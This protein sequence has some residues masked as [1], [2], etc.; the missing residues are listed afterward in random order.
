MASG[1]KIMIAVD[2]T[3]V[4][5]YAFTWA[6]HNLL[7]KSDQVIALTAAPFVDITYPSADLASEYGPTVIPSAADAEGN[8]KHVNTDAKKLIAR[9]IAQCAQADISCTG[10]VVK[11][12][13][14][15]WI[16]D[17]ANR[18]GADVIVVGSKGSGALKRMVMGSNSDYV[19]HNATCPVAVVRHVEEELKDHDAL[20]STGGSR[21]VVIAVDESR[22]SVFAF[23]WALENF[24]TE[25]DSVVI[26]HVNQSIPPVTTAGTGEFGIEEV[27]VPSE[28]QGKTEVQALDES[29]KLV[30]KYM[31][32]A[33][34]ETKI[35]CEGI[36]VTGQPELKVIEGLTKLGAD[37]VIIGTHDRSAVSRTLLSSITDH[38]A[39]NSPCPLIVARMPKVPSTD[40]TVATSE[41]KQN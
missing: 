27:Y 36:V 23:K 24:A 33:A 35:K 39:H 9:C 31:A 19:L 41:H 30:E 4:S 13:A 10:E 6:L 17:E 25:E 32:F 28:S 7:R 8:A 11:G 5:A 14:G 21:K 22:E 18:L 38:L 26:Y 15:T 29:E 12:D 16:V 3:E 20:N 1:R 34:K 40:S 37:A 2:H